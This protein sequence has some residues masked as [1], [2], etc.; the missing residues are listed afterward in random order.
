MEVRQRRRDLIDGGANGIVGGGNVV[1]LQEF[2]GKAL[3]GFQ[4]RGRLRW[5]KNSPT[6]T[7]EL[8]H[9]AERQGKLGTD[10]RQAGLDAAGGFQQRVQALDV[11]GNAF[12]LSTDAPVSGRAIE[13]RNS[14]RL[15]QLPHQSMF[16]PAA[17]NDQDFHR[18]KKLE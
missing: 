17:A 13:L 10:N 11:S 4:A 6:A 18:N 2:L 1:A 7:G 3:A 5:P 8:V 9:D 12:G 15:P 16:A 14:R